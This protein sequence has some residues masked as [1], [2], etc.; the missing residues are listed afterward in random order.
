MVEDEGPGINVEDMPQIFDRLY[1]GDKNRS[2]TVPGHGLGLS[3]AKE[4]AKV[5]DAGLS[6]ANLAEGGAR[7]TLTVNLS[8]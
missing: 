5:N 8:V 7:F 6:V 3:L 2:K 4:I 1:R